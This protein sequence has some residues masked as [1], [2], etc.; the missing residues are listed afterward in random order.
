MKITIIGGAGIRTV[1]FING[2][3][4]RC[5]KLSITEVVLY[6]IDKEKLLV[7]EALCQ[8]IAERSGTN[9]HIWG[10]SDL[11]CAL[12]GASYVVTTLRVGGDH[13]RVMDERVALTC[14]V[15]GQETTGAGG[16]SMAIRTIPVLLKYCEIIRRIVPDAWIFNFTNPSGLVTQ[17]LYDAGY[18][19]I[20]G[21]CDAPDST[22]RRMA[23]SL[24]VSPDRL[25]TEF[26]GLNHLSFIRSVKVDGE[27]LLP[28]LLEDI[29]FL[30]SVQEFSR[31]DP[32]VMRLTGCLPNE[33]LYYYYHREKALENILAAPQTRG[34][35]IEALNRDMFRE[36]AQMDIRRMPEEALQ[37]FLYY[38]YCRE[39]S[40]MQIETGDHQSREIQ[41]GCLKVPSGMGYAGIMLD[42]I[43]GL[44]SNTGKD[45]VLCVPNQ[46]AIAGFADDD[47]VEISCHVSASGGI[48]PICV[49]DMPEH[50]MML[51]KAVKRY[52]KQTVR[53]VRTGSRAAALDALC[54]HPLVMSWS[55]GEKL[56]RQYEAA[57]GD[58]FLQKTDLCGTDSF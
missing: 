40:Y 48:R 46:G 17:A 43:E 29:D 47:I 54:L 51:M 35:S 13:A 6:D 20:I 9:L 34:E 52:E 57:Y 25:H 50:C 27:E 16:F 32:A 5:Q 8:Y 23:D 2:L 41:K 45:L 39:F 10:E 19:R 58:S 37:T 24:G 33:Y 21:I 14:G 49:A 38:I 53:A 56:L 36:L 15:I 28:R 22:H 31:I 4:D 12:R 55:L 18:R 42:C 1:N 30:K 26:F 3:L 44:Q 11:E 7:I